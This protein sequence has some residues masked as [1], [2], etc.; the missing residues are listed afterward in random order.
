MCYEASLVTVTRHSDGACGMFRCLFL[1]FKSSPDTSGILLIKTWLEH[2]QPW[3]FK[4]FLTRHIPA[5]IIAF[6]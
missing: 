6:K 1:R 3:K 4:R 2:V 5:D